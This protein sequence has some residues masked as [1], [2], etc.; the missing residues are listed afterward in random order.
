MRP[1]AIVLGFLAAL[2]LECTSSD[3]LELDGSTQT[4]DTIGKAADVKLQKK[5]DLAHPD[6]KVTLP[7]DQSTVA[8]PDTGVPDVDLPEL[9]DPKRLSLPFECSGTALSASEVIEHVADGNGGFW[10]GSDW[11]WQGKIELIVLRDYRRLCNPTTGCDAW[12]L[13]T[14][15]TQT[16]IRPAVVVDSAKATHL[17]QYS[18]S[19]PAQLLTSKSF[20]TADFQMNLYNK[21][22]DPSSIVRY[23]IRITRSSTSTGCFSMAAKTA[24]W[25][26]T[27]NPSWTV[28]SVVVGVATFAAP[29][30]RQT[31]PKPSGSYTCSGTPASDAQIKAAFPPARSS[32][33]SA[34][35]ASRAGR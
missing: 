20:S 32:S 29:T 12:S 16:E 13:T 21:A 15:L 24:S 33:P 4:Q 19:N 6:H 9:D 23:K 14:G 18:A 17:Y 22:N 8:P 26:S 25:P 5:K 31:Y 30:P 1:M 35:R 28:Q 3:P 7:P 2:L 11:N 34:T 10:V 27:S